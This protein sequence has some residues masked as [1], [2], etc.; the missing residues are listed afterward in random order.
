MG[1]IMTILYNTETQKTVSGFL[2]PYYIVD[3]QRP[4]LP[5]NVVELEVN[6]V[7]TPQY[8]KNTQ[9]I[10][11]EWEVNL[12]DKTYYQKHTIIDKSQHEILMENWVFINFDKRVL[13][14]EKDVTDKPDLNKLIS[15]IYLKKYPTKSEINVNSEVFY[16][17]YKSS[18]SYINDISLTLDL[19][20]EDI[21]KYLFFDY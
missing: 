11:S 2:N 20:V 10:Q 9:R 17:Y 7:N 6:Y 15:L 16:L 8:D 5:Q 13:V 21:P 3:G 4:D 1:G 18:D 19:P 14:T 12:I